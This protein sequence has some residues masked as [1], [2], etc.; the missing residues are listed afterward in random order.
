LRE[1][2]VRIY[3]EPEHAAEAGLGIERMDKNAAGLQQ[4]KQLRLVSPM[5][6]DRNRGGVRSFSSLPEDLEVVGDFFVPPVD[7]N[8]DP[9]NHVVILLDGL[10]R[11]LGIEQSRIE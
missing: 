2:F 4:C 5:H 11:R 8:L 1:E 7:T 3:A 10:N 6:H 9:E